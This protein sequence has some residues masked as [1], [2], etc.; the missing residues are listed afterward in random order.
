MATVSSKP[1]AGHLRRKFHDVIKIKLSS[2][3]DEA[4]RR[5]GEFYEIEARIKG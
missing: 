2:L 1:L 4:L 3:A 5:I